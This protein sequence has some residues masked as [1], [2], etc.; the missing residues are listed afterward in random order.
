MSKNINALVLSFYI[1]YVVHFSGSTIRR[2]NQDLRL[3]SL[4]IQGLLIQALCAF[5]P[6]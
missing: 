4:N 2:L 5:Y 3:L 6:T 1:P